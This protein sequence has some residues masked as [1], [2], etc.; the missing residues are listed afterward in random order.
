MCRQRYRQKGVVGCTSETI[1]EDALHGAF[2]KAWNGIVENRAK[3]MERWKR[4]IQ[5]DDPLLA[6]RAKQMIELTKGKPIKK[7]DMALVGKVLDHYE[8]YFLDGTCVKIV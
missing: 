5:G 7:I 2:V 1:K 3:Y 4:D 8:F 6:F